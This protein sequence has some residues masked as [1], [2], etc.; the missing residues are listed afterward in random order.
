MQ[1]RLFKR[2]SESENKRID[3]NLESIK[4][5]FATYEKITLPVVE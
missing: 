1:K 4:K 2:I 3:D 5:R